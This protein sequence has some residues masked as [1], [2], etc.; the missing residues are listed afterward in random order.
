MGTSRLTQPRHR[1]ASSPA[2][3][4]PLTVTATQSLF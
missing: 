3:D 2:P 4:D 1:A